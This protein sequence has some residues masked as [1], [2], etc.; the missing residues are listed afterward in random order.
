MKT[1]FVLIFAI[2]FIALI[3]FFCGCTSEIP[4]QKNV[5]AEVSYFNK[6][7]SDKKDNPVYLNAKK[8]NEDYRK[9]GGE[10]GLDDVRFN[11]KY[12]YMVTPKSPFIWSIY[13]RYHPGDLVV[14]DDNI[15][16]IF[17]VL[18][19]D[20]DREVFSPVSYVFK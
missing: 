12:R 17:H 10:N 7:P 9:S 3:K 15:D 19:N 8:L 13:I 18:T 4:P 20:I 11:T 6:K 5:T 16:G 1:Y 14:A 2:M